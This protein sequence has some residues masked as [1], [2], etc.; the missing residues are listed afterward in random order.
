MHYAPR[1]GAHTRSGSW[2]ACR[3]GHR[4]SCG[5]V[6]WLVSAARVPGYCSREANSFSKAAGN[7]FGNA[8]CRLRP[9]WTA[10]ATRPADLPPLST[11]NP[12]VRCPCSLQ[13]E[14]ISDGTPPPP[15]PALP[16]KR[17]QLPVV[18]FGSAFLFVSK[19]CFPS[20]IFNLL[21]CK[22]WRITASPLKGRFSSRTFPSSL[23]I[24]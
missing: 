23:P 13:K 2:Q 24:P 4:D 3:A 12:L 14:E 9:S 20:L 11:R 21:L 7:G 17:R 22:T 8:R 1:T 6:G 19:A 15:A 18:A 5:R 16:D 10:A